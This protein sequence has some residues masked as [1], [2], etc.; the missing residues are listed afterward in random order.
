MNIKFREPT[1]A[2]KKNFKETINIKLISL[3]LS[4]FMVIIGNLIIQEVSTKNKGWKEFFYGSDHSEDSS[5]Y[6]PIVMGS[7]LLL[8]LFFFYFT[9]KIIK[10][11]WDT[12]ER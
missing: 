4:G 7:I 3:V 10:K 9:G 6:L 8:S 2:E 1:D 5:I 11:I 12:R